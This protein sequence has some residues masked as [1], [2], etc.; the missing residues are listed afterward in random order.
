[1]KKISVLFGLLLSLC[2]LSPSWAVLDMELTNGNKQAVPLGIASWTGTANAGLRQQLLRTIE[3]DLQ[4]SGWF[5]LIQ[6]DGQVPEVFRQKGAN[7]LL[8]G[9]LNAQSNGTLR[10]DVQ[11]LGL[12]GGSAANENLLQMHYQVNPKTLRGLA[13]RVSDQIFEKL[14]G[15]RGNFSTK[16]AY[17]KVDYRSKYVT[18][19]LVVADADGRNPHV[20]LRSHQP[21]M[22]PAWTPDG[23]Q[24]AYVSFAG[25]QA[26]IYLQSL[27]TGKRHRL[28]AAPGINGAPAFSPDGSKMAVVLTKT[29][30]PNI[31][32][33]NLVTKQ[34]RPITSGWSID[35]EPAWSPDGRSLLFTS[36]RDGSPQIY[37]Y[38]FEDKSIK[39]LTF[40][41]NY[42]ARARWL[43]SGDGFIVMHR[44]RGET[45]FSVGL[46]RLDSSRMQSLT[47]A[48]TIESPSIA[49]NGQM[50]VYAIKSGLGQVSIDSDITLS[51]PQQHGAIQEPAWSPFLN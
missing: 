6:G 7:A 44:D 48:G 12:Y 34:M 13:H 2:W 22:S 9:T 4:N 45:G 27:A 5:H 32:E 1:M 33:L 28:L 31:Y 38:R 14:T 26:Q 40:S 42:N 21:L 43:P 50:V 37:Q 23:K 8:R 25:H 39:R 46:Q 20:I 47:A 24:L 18:Y 19:R 11:V 3:N 15:V 30:N 36:N 41:G 49:P 10:L 35:T 17:V 51:L 29:G 16:I